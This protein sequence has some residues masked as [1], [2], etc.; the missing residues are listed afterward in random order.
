M[1][2][3]AAAAVGL[4][5]GHVI[6]RL[7]LPDRGTDFTQALE[8]AY[9]SGQLRRP[10]RPPPRGLQEQVDTFYAMFL[11]NLVGQRRINLLWERT[12]AIMAIS[13]VAITLF[14]VAILILTR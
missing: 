5:A 14:V 8:R 9:M 4:V 6:L 1:E 11:E 7:C 10:G 13:V 12:Q 3:L 2:A